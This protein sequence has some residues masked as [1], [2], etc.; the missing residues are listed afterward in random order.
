M[1]RVILFLIIVGALALG[2]AWLADRPGDVVVTWQGWRIETS[3]MV[4]GAALLAALAVLALL[5]SLLR[6]F[7]RSPSR[8]RAHLHRRRGERAYE[9][10]SRGLIAV[11]AGDLDAARKHTA[12]AKR[13]AP[14]EPL[15]LLLHAQAA[16]L[17]GDREAADSAFRAMAGRADT[18]ALGLRG[19]FIEAHRRGDH[20]SARALAEEAA[21]QNPALGWAGKA[22]LEMRCATGDWAGALALLEGNKRALDKESYRRQRAVMLTA[23]ALALEE[24]DRDNAKAFALEAAKLAPTLVP[25]AALAGR[26]LAEGGEPRK[27]RRIL[28]KAWLANPHPHLAQAY[29]QLRFGDAARDRLKRMEA[30]AQKVPG[31]IEG[32]LALARAAIDAQDYAKARAA[33]APH[34]AALTKRVALLM[35]ELERAERN[36]EGRVREWI[37]RAVHAAPDPA[38]TADGHVSDRWLPVSPVSGR[39]DAFEWRVPL[40][41]IASAATVINP[42]PTAAAP[43]AAAS[44]PRSD[45]ARIAHD[46]DAATI[47]EE[48]AGTP[49]AA[50]EL[51]AIP[52][53]QRRGRSSEPKPE[54]VI[55][56]VHAPDD[57]GPDAAEENE[58]PG[59]QENGGWRKIF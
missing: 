23:R 21:R 16:Q 26:M 12:N 33:L 7:L 10:I 48:K 41:G 53:S 20:A 34:L 38:W 43:V 44:E 24:T 2:V 3:L 22:V 30:L 11:G 54:A 17:A 32:A 59:E 27:A 39:L 47:A 9:A 36:D 51:A 28:D 19:L 29:A 40:A 52:P 18:K 46:K 31:H 1:I 8:L 5:W 45:G 6:A 57:P 15:A 50:A 13:M 4:L 25:A 42:Q 56:L 55:P 35:A 37:A 14:A 58:P 49:A